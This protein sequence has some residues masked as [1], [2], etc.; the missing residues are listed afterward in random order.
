MGLLDVLNS[1]QGRLGLSLLAAAGPSPVPQSFGQRLM[2]GLLQSEEMKRQQEQALQARQF[3]DMQMQQM[4]L[5]Y[6]QALKAQKQADLDRT[7]TQQAFKPVQPIEANQASGVTGPRPQALGV[8]GQMPKFDLAQAIGAGMTPD[9]AFALQQAMTKQQAKIKD[10]KEVRM[11]DGSVQIVGFDEY[12]K[13][14]DTGRTPFKDAVEMDLG[15]TKAMRDPITGKIVNQFAKSNTPDALLSAQTTIRGQNL[16]DARAREA[17]DINKQAAR[18]QVVNDAERGTLLVDKGTGLIRPA[19]GMDGKPM[20][21]EAQVASAKRSGQLMATM[22]QAESLLKQSPTGSYAGAGIDQAARV[23]GMAP[24]SAETAAQLETLSGWLV[25]NV[26]RMEGP[27][28]NID[29][30]NYKTMAA[31][32]GDRTLPVSV[33][34]ASLETLRGIQGKYS[35]LNGGAPA[36][37]PSGGLKFLGFEGQ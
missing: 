35:E 26:P 24:K 14:V 2:G 27:Q 8:V 6:Q 36:R 28:S 15:G 34:L 33:R 29:V 5:Q 10:F 21:S 23:F 13:P 11:P 3:R 19:V 4:A 22:E 30:E 31:R 9:R 1:D 25:A 37:A 12:G 17:N 7:L 32:V 18:V 16:T 20:R